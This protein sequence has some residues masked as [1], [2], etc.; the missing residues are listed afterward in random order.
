MSKS[1]ILPPVDLEK[2]LAEIETRQVANATQVALTNQR[3]FR[4]KLLAVLPQLSERL[5]AYILANPVDFVQPNGFVER[6]VPLEHDLTPGQL[7][8]IKLLM[9]KHMPNLTPVSSK[10]GDDEQKDTTVR[11]SITQIGPN[12]DPKTVKQ[13]RA[14]QVGTITIN[15]HD[16]ED[17]EII[18]DESKA[19]PQESPTEEAKPTE[20]EQR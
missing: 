12:A 14:E 1:E 3:L 4:E 9:N 10:T 7:A 11:I 16:A 19:T 18:E 2:S 15:R 20:K 8:I 13:A 17:A 6:R 5:I